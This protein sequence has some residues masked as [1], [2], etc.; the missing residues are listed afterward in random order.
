M[1]T[2]AYWLGWNLTVAGLVAT[3]LHA[4]WSVVWTA[5]SILFCNLKSSQAARET[6]EQI[7][8]AYIRPC[9]SLETRPVRLETS[10]SLLKQYSPS[11]SESRFQVKSALYYHRYY[12]CTS[13][14]IYWRPGL[15]ATLAIP[16]IHIRLASFP[17]R[18]C[19]NRTKL[20]KLG[21]RSVIFRVNSAWERG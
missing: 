19:F 12:S 10:T 13:D 7:P 17:G 21:V 3:A 4:G 11:P 20:K 6:D 18:F 15:E 5:N 9:N 2:I 14:V 8:R 16:C 1:T